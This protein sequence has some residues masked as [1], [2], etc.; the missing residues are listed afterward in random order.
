MHLSG[1]GIVCFAASYSVALALEIS[2]IFFRS[3]IRGA[4]MLGFAAAGFFA[5]T[6]FLVHRAAEATGSPLSSKQEWY[7]VAAWLLA[8]VYLY[9]AYF[10]PKNAFG[11]FILPL[12]LALI[13]VG[14]L[15][16]DTV[17]FARESASK[18]WGAIHAI[19]ILL[20]T[21]SMLVGFAAGVMYLIQAY[22]LKRKL[23]PLRG[24]Q[25]PS[26]EWLQRVNA[27]AILISLLLMGVGILAGVVLNLINYER[28][29][30]R[31]PWDDPLVL[32]TLG[33]FGWLL[34]STAVGVVYKPT[35][36][37]RKVAYLTVV[38]LVF[39]IIAL[40]IGMSVVT[41]HAGTGTSLD[42][43][44][45]RDRPNGLQIDGPERGPGWSLLRGGNLPG[46]T[47]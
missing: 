30:S 29:L 6:V 7:L 10:H 42:R 4:V 46:G 5:H 27:R 32:S 47:A 8:G 17:P 1:V 37:G 24:L 3:G 18:V 40:G 28:Q 26:L 19:S 38:S 12:V 11:V 25:L 23:P 13:G 41:Q 22:R 45:H 44:R 43:E 39:L 14:T 33:L 21:V 35:R 9:L 31:L 36:Q 16:A 15:A 20:A 34:L 2:R